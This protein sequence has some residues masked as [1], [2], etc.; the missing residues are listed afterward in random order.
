M[1]ASRFALCDRGSVGAICPLAGAVAV[2][3]VPGWKVFVTKAA[4][5][6]AAYTAPSAGRK[7]LVTL[8]AHPR[9]Q[10]VPNL[11]K[12]GPLDRFAAGW[13]GPRPRI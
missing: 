6:R 11:G 1:P 9:D 13:T 3:D 12:L 8:A 4:T 5:A 10:D 7:A 2:L